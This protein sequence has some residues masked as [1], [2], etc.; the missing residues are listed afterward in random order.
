MLIK[1]ER[2]TTKKFDVIK[3]RWAK[4]FSIGIFS[5]F[6]SHVVFAGLSSAYLMG[7]ES[8]RLL[9]VRNFNKFDWTDLISAF[10]ARHSNVDSLFAGSSFMWGYSWPQD[11]VLTSYFH[12]AL[13]VS[14][15]GASPDSTI[16]ALNAALPIKANRVIVEINPS[17]MG[18][19]LPVYEPSAAL[20]TR[21]SY[22]SFFLSRFFGTEIIGAA[23]NQYEY[24]Q[25]EIEYAQPP[26]PDDYFLHPND[27]EAD[28]VLE[29]LSAIANVTRE[30]SEE[31]YLFFSPQIFDGSPRFLVETYEKLNAICAQESRINCIDTT[32]FQEKAHFANVSH[33]NIRGH[34]AFASFLKKQI[35]L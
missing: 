2:E 10:A 21:D 5:I 29:R 28:R 14:M 31:T 20:P 6:M 4:V 11:V 34:A 17:N 27:I 23:Y 16:Q 12:N 26:L 8:H 13:N 9:N 3:S 35:G 1:S 15:I 24:D 22:F 32:G 30:I 33:L 18:A 7:M 19:N 25:A